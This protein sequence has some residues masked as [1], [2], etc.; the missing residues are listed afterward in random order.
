MSPAG[1]TKVGMPKWGLAMTAGRVTAWLVE[2]GAAVRA[3]DEVAEVETEKIAGVVEAPAAGML[4]RRAAQPGDLVPVGGLLGVIADASVPD[5][6]V[7]AFVAEF[8]A[9]FVPEAGEEAGA[10]APET[11]EVGGRRIRYLRQGDGGVPLV[12]V[13]GFGAD[14]T[15]WLFNHAALGAGRAA[16]ALDLPGHGG[17]TKDVGAGD[18]DLF[19]GVLAGFLAATGL[20]RVHVAGHSMG[21]AV[22]IATALAH[23]DRVASLTLIASAGLG[24][25]ING[26]YLDGFVAARSRRELAPLLEQ[27]VADRRV[28]TRQLVDDVLK[29]KRLD[30]VEAALR[31]VVAR[32]FPAGRQAHV[33]ASRLAEA[34]VPVLGIF[35]RE[36]RIVP[37]AH[38]EALPPR[39]EVALLDGVGHMPHM[40]AAGEVNRL[41]GRLLEAS[42]AARRAS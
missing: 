14:L 8:R 34:S 22:A 33:L 40:E 31:T 9:T 32:L 6:E 24:P 37:A 21:G 30:G 29:Y 2:E 27:I 41:I 5:P 19:A 39:A 28:L 18:L 12:L 38:A 35:G 7:D 11:V 13:H 4:R 17:S 15:T 16:Y 3:G 1:I 25:E 10:P 23:P 42:S 36:D 26:A 20:G